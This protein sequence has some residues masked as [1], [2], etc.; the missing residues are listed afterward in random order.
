[1]SVLPARV[2]PVSFSPRAIERMDARKSKVQSW[3]LDV[4]M[5]KNY[6]TG[7]GGRGYLSHR[8]DQHGLRAPR[9]ARDHRRR[10]S[11]SSESPDIARCT[12]CCVRVWKNWV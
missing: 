8:A 1:M 6:Y 9:S 12:C 2:S 11:R 5:L 3:Y 7:G 10:R 4:S